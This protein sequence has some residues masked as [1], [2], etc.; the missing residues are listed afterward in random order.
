MNNVP[1]LARLLLGLVFVL[2]GLNGFFDF[3]PLEAPA[4]EA[5]AFLGALGA[6]GYLLPLIKITE[7][8]AGALLL[9]NRHVTLATLMLAPIVINILAF[10]VFLDNSGMLMAVAVSALE[11]Y[12]LYENRNNLKQL[13]N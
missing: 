10:H 8:V 12:M 6:S 5:G 11:G 1:Q 4:G 3:I 7:I 9:A 13:L 2:F